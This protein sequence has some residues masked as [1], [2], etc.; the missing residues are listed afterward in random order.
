MAVVVVG[1]GVVILVVLVVCSNN[2]GLGSDGLSTA[3]A[4][5]RKNR[6]CR[7]TEIMSIFVSELENEILCLIMTSTRSWALPFIPALVSCSWRVGVY[8]YCK[9]VCM[10]LRHT[11]DTSYM[12]VIESRHGFCFQSCFRISYDCCLIITS[13]VSISVHYCPWV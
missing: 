3:D 7:R 13:T 9:Y 11:Q 8:V 12:Q 6:M 5:R 1:G 4:S 10:M 2:L